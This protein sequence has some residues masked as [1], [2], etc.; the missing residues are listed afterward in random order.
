MDKR[1]N[2]TLLLIKFYEQGFPVH[3]YLL[4]F[5][6]DVYNRNQNAMWKISWIKICYVGLVSVCAPLTIHSGKC[7]NINKFHRNHRK[8]LFLLISF[9]FGAVNF[10]EDF[11]ASLTFNYVNKFIL[12]LL[13]QDGSIEFEEFI[14]ALSITSRGNLDEKLHC[15]YNLLF[16]NKVFLLPCCEIVM[17]VLGLLLEDSL[18]VHGQ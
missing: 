5:T 4:L 11:I 8:K 2:I 18:R 12:L 7:F 1:C 9:T 3:I 6:L 14:R 17:S 15:K 10:Q 13:Q 16:V